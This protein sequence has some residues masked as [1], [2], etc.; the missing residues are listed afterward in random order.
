MIPR[1]GQTPHSIWLSIPANELMWL[2][3]ALAHVN[4]SHYDPNPTY[5]C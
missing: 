1:M 2:H 4:P 5:T 3:R